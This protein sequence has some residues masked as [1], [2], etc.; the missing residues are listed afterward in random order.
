VL[1][2]NKAVSKQFGTALFVFLQNF[3]QFPYFYQR[4]KIGWIIEAGL[5]REV[6]QKRLDYL[7]KMTAQGKQYG[8]QP[9]KDIVL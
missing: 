7:I 8:T 3:Q 4:L 9:L 6:A 2:I 1:S 5:R